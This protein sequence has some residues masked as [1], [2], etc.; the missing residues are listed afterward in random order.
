MRP[1]WLLAI[2]LTGAGIWLFIHPDSAAT[3][4]TYVSGSAPAPKTDRLYKWRNGQGE[5]QVTDTLPPPGTGYETLD[6][7][8]DLN[9]LPV[10]PRPD[11]GH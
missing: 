10:P 7:R 8:A 11:D 5:W 1:V 9:V 6:Y 2:L 3:W 4:W